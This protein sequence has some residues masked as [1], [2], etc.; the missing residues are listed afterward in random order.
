MLLPLHLIYS[1]VEKTRS[2]SSTR[3]L[4]I[5]PWMHSVKAIEEEKKSA[6]AKSSTQTI[7]DDRQRNCRRL[8]NI[9]S[10]F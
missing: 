2:M 9:I 4:Q 6:I 8:C 1:D 10:L 3:C 7:Y 5:E